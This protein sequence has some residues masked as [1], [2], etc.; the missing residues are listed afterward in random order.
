[1]REGRQC[2]SIN[3]VSDLAHNRVRPTSGSVAPGGT[4]DGPARAHLAVDRCRDRHVRSDLPRLQVLAGASGASLAD[5]FHER[6]IPGRRAAANPAPITPGLCL[7]IPGSRPPSSS[8]PR[9]D[10]A[11]DSNFESAALGNL[12]VRRGSARR[13]SC[14]C[15][16]AT[17]AGSFPT[18]D[19]RVAAGAGWA[20]RAVFSDPVPSRAGRNRARCGKAGRG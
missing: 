12:R 3:P 9:N 14:A 11:Y 8:S 7:W 1:M 4:N 18:R 16:S 20:C 15:P 13:E 6:V 5:R 17:R 19:R 2:R 10:G